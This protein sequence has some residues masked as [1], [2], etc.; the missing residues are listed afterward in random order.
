[1]VRIRRKFICVCNFLKQ[2]S[3]KSSAS[4]N[5]EVSTRRHEERYSP[6]GIR[7]K[8]RTPVAVIKKQLGEKGT[9]A[10][11]IPWGMLNVLN[12]FF[13]FILILFIKL[14]TYKRTWN[15]LGDTTKWSL[16]WLTNMVAM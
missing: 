2:F 14:I 8:G 5:A 7:I 1:M 3:H 13:I 16:E 6:S 4:S 15:W 10:C 11:T 9:L 12:F